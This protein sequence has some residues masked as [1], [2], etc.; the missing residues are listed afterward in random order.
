MKILIHGINYA[1]EIIG[2]GK[3]TGELGRWLAARGHEVRVVTAPPYYP[4][5]RVGEGYSAGRYRRESIAGVDVWRC[6]LWVP[7]KP[8]GLKRLLH[9]AS[10]AS[11]SF[12]IM[13]RQAL[14]R[15]DVVMLI[16][17]PLLGAPRRG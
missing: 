7:E 15:P 2:T 5:W 14:W 10:F 17:P 3:Y 9:L 1:P 6:P 13:L 12:P 11:S 16:E 8:S 4:A